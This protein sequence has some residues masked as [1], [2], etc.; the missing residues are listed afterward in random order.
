MRTLVV[1]AGA[2]G[3][4]FGG[5]MLAKGRDVT[6]LVRPKRA[7]ELAKSGLVI[8]SP[9][10]DLTVPN[11]PTVLASNLHERYDLILLSCKAY[12]LDEAIASF[13]PAV[14]PNTAILPMLNGM[15]HID[16][17]DARFGADCVLGGQCIIS[18]TLNTER[19]I[20]HMPLGNE[21]TFGA[22]SEALSERAKAFQAVLSDCN[23]TVHLS[24]TI[25]QD[26]WN[27]WV[28]IASL[29]SNTTLMRATVGQINQTPR[30]REIA[31]AIFDEVAT[32]AAENG[33]TLATPAKQRVT[34][35]LTA[36]SSH[37]TASMFR[38]MQASAPVEA[39]QIIGDLIARRRRAPD[40][41]ALLDVVYANL[42]A[43]ELR[44]AS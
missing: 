38:D 33:Y 42:K 3:G 41:I 17:L 9:D 39:D 29:A 22:R 10:G 30:G 18:T 34:M 4:Y 15:R 1:G 35:M 5:R 16:V 23:F 31:L 32:I 20:V 7:E 25:L 43:Y 21:L 6:F 2:I 37:L 40:G 24:T 28:G 8:K 44:R 26:M 36:E 12:D 13:A 19:E 11:P 27:K 14:G